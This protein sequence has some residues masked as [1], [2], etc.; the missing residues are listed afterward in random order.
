MN[1]K[2]LEQLTILNDRLDSFSQ[3]I[4]SVSETVDCLNI[5]YQALCDIAEALEDAAKE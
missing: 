4:E 1:D 3:T 2:V 5:E